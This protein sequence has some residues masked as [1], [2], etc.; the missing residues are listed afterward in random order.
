MDNSTIK[1]QAE[2]DQAKSIKNTHADIDKLQR[3]ID[4]LEIK[5]KIDPKAI[6][7]FKSLLQY[8]SEGA[9]KLSSWQNGVLTFTKV[10]DATHQAVN[11]VKELDTAL[12]DLNRTAQSSD[13]QQIQPPENLSEKQDDLAIA[14]DAEIAKSP[15]IGKEIKSILDA[16]NSL[17]NGLDWL[18]GKVKTF[19]A[20]NALINTFVKNFA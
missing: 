20:F 12:T 8:L 18:T 16:I 19:G 1:I 3:K 2:L 14:T 13:F 5:A 4:K 9:K 11:A 17:G 15:S 10:I 6:S 7:N